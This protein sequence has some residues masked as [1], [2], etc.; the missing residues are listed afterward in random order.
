MRPG[1]A[2]WLTH[3]LAAMV[4]LHR[5][6]ADPVVDY[7]LAPQQI[8]EQAV[9]FGLRGMGLKEKTIARYYNPKALALFQ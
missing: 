9:W 8:V 7:A 1:L 3:H 6:P 4:M 5:L 2:G